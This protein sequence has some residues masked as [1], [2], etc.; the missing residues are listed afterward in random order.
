MNDSREL[1]Q[2]IMTAVGWVP[3]GTCELDGVEGFN[4]VIAG[5]I[6]VYYFRVLMH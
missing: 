1:P 6:G 3:D 5:F 2:D 4:V